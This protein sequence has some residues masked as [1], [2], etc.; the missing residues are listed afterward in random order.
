M[1]RILVNTNVLLD[2]IT[3]DP[4]WFEWSLNIL[5]KYASTHILCINA[6]IYAELSIGF[7]QKIELD[8]FIK[9]AQFYYLSELPLDTL[10][11][12]G[13]VFLKYRRSS[14]SKIVPLPDFFIGAH[15]ITENIALITR[16]KGHY[17]TYFPALKLVMPHPLP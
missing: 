17:Q 13:K 8:N 6:I 16:D 9:E 11:L 4:N 15:A 14:G 12:A 1:K 10:F 5:D 2:I 7:K 3:N